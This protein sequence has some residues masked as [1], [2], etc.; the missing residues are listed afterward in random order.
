M[1]QG[2]VQGVKV[3]EKCLVWI[4]EEDDNKGTDSGR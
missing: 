1:T 4:C 2:C 3:N